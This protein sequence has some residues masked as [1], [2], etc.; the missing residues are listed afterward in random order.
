[1]KQLAEKLQ[2]IKSKVRQRLG[3][4]FNLD[5]W[6]A[7]LI[8]RLRQGYDSIMVMGTGYGKSVIFEGLAAGN[9]AKIVIVICPL[10]ALERDP[11]CQPPMSPNIIFNMVCRPTKQKK[12]DSSQKW[13]MKIPSVP[14]CGQIFARDEPISTM[15]PLRWHYPPASFICGRIGAFAIVCKLW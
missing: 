5:D 11:V 13:S 9:K 10:K 6:Q 3:L 8:R 4:G 15:Y 7:E 1:V 14:S 2:D 12:R